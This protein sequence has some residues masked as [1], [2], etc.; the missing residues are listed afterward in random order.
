MTSAAGTLRGLVLACHPVPTVAVTGFSVLL[1]LGLGAPGRTL[2]VATTAVLAGQLSIGWSND[3]L[4][5]ERD[6]A[7]GRWDKPVVDGLVTPRL[8]WVTALCAVAACVAASL[9][10]GW[11]PG[12]VHLVAVAGAWLYN[13]WL[14]RTAWSPLAYAVSFGLLPVFLGL[15]L[16][17]EPLV[18]GWV[19][20]TGVLLGL[21]AHLA[22][23]LPDIEADLATGVRGLPHRLGRR[24]TTLLAPVVLC[25]AVLV[26]VFGPG[27]PGRLDLAGGALAVVAA[28]GAAVTAV[29]RPGSRLPFL[30]AVAVAGTCVALLVA[31]GPDLLA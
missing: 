13:L 22:N 18:A 2:G 19:V 8:L 9:A 28:G 14:K 25:L 16:P 12:V 31:A 4:D 20:V 15:T 23:V 26:V 5:A 21:G 3:W 29:R 27:P 1:L 30:L 17:G 6:V 24:T 10:T 11:R 7:T